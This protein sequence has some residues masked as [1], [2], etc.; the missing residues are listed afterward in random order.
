MIPASIRYER[1]ATIE[2]AV[3]A[4]FQY[5][6]NARPLAGGQSLIPWMRLR[7]LTP[8]VLVDLAGIRG[9]A[10]VR[11][12]AGSVRVGALATH[13]AVAGSPNFAGLP[14]FADAGHDLGDVQVRNRGTVIGALAHAAPTGDW[15]AVA[16]AAGATLNIFGP[17][18]LR[19]TPVD[20]FFTGP[21]QPDLKPGEVITEM[22][23]PTGGP[24]VSAYAKLSSGPFAFALAGVAVVATTD[25][26]GT[27]I[28]ARLAATGVTTSPVRLSTSEALMMGR[29]LDPDAIAAA[30]EAAPHGIHAM[31]DQ[32]ASADYRLHLL[33]VACRRAL[34]TAA[35][36]QLT[37]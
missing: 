16:I 14:L 24:T 18:G 10:G 5:G 4:L 20:Q 21:F 19:S 17:S 11:P 31:D 27:V 34:T 3:E 30:A 1:P 22:I 8:D 9:L 35:R 28:S 7:R 32:A 23:V 33:S 12:E 2:A 6:Q 37:A 29:A 25:A 15:S 36:R 26:Q 13:H